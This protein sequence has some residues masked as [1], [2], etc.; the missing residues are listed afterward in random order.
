M[1]NQIKT[2][3]VTVID[4]VTPE[5]AKLRVA[6]YARVSSDSADQI[7]SYLAQVDYYTRH[8]GENPDWELAD[9]YADEGISGLD[10]LKRV[11]FNRMLA[12]CRAGKIDRILIKSMSRFAR[13]TRDSLHFMRE[14]MRLGVTV[15]F[16]KENIDTGKLSS[17]QT[18]SASR[19]MFLN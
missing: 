7:N 4:P 8:I 14:L 11:E 1:A 12:D 10:T 16:E 19:K 9:I 18:C 13:N 17:E 5:K 2:P 6:A 3:R 15:R